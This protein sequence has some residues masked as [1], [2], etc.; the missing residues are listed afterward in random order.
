M[1][2]GKT[3]LVLLTKSCSMS[4]IAKGLVKQGNLVGMMTYRNGHIVEGKQG[5]EGEE[6]LAEGGPAPLC[7][8]DGKVLCL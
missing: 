3:C 6:K 8:E 1:M 7:S 4:C 2:R 5:K